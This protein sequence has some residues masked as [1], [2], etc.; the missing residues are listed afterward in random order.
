MAVVV[1]SGLVGL[2]IGLAL[3]A[4][5]PRIG[6]ELG[7]A[8]EGVASQLGTTLV[9]ALVV[10]AATAL[11][12]LAGA[13][14]VRLIRRSPFR[15]LSQLVVAGA[16]GAILIDVGCLFLLGPL[17][18]FWLLPLLVVQL[19]LVAACTLLA[20]PWLAAGALGRPAVGL[21]AIVLVVAVWSAPVVLQLASPV[22]PFVD[23]LP[24][25][26][27]PV[28]H[29]RAYATWESLVVSPSPIYGPSR[30][31]LGYVAVLGTVTQLTGL[32]A[33]LAVSAFTLPLALLL[34]ASARVMAQSLVARP[35]PPDP[36][37]SRRD[38]TSR[39]AAIDP[40]AGL[41]VL[42]TVPLTFTFLRLP[43][44][45]ASV[46]GFIPV[47]LAIALLAG[48][49]RWL[50]RARP[51]ML[52][53]AIGS[54]ILVHPPT[55]VLLAATIGLAGL[56]S[57]SRVRVAWSGVVGG[58]LV[59]LPQGMGMLGASVPA[60]LGVPV[61]VIG[62]VLAAILGPIAGSGARPP[63]RAPARE[64]PRRTWIVTGALAATAV[65]LLAG[66]VLREPAILT[67]LAN[68]LVGIASDWWLLLAALLLAIATVRSA[69]AWLAI[70]SAVVVG[71]AAVI[72]AEAIA[73]FS[74]DWS[75]LVESIAFEVPKSVGYWLPWFI[76]VAGGLGLAALWTR[77]DGAGIVRVAVGALFAFFAAISLRPEAVDP[78]RIEQHAY[79]ENLA[80]ALQGAQDGYWV[81]HPDSRLVIDAP[82]AEL[83]D[84][85]REQ[86]RAGEIGPSTALL[87][88]APS[89]QQWEATPLGVFTG[90]IESDATSDPERSIHTV[91]GRLHD[92]RR[93]HRLLG[94]RYP[95]LVVEGITESWPLEAA[96]SAGYRPVWRNERAVLLRLE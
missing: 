15:S 30:V 49:D 62:L 7:H 45:R 6:Y 8:V 64:I 71:V 26:V 51:M 55:G 11:N 43:D 39:V 9:P 13:G 94:P 96:A 40:W 81:G 5:S 48:G 54:T 16:V 4:G 87:H 20:R 37:A 46:L 89:F 47:A 35:V 24:N 14:A 92:I 38:A 2:V 36:T 22:P 50:G 18:W 29:L 34:A 44:V 31:F 85:V 66:A 57:P 10:L 27:A 77:P 67:D 69:V 78:E 32:A 12:V 79:A 84:A 25:H 68:A 1:V 21:P 19:A 70:G 52:A 33:S 28:E 72:T 91:G 23:V 17:G 56:L 82:R 3:L 75:T 83:V 93:M 65:V 41:W 61:M 42:L 88:V 60:W 58:A 53:G 86:Q 63:S 95:W 76:A 74:P 90:V 73:R 80:I 59:G